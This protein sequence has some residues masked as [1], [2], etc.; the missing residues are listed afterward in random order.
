MKKFV[1]ELSN[2]EARKYFLQASK[3][4]TIDLPKYFDFQSLLNN[5]ERKIE[6]RKLFDMI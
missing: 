6:K 3:F 2:E 1:I 5:L 4:C